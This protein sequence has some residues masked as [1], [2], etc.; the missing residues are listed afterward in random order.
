MSSAIKILMGDSESSPQD[1]QRRRRVEELAQRVSSGIAFNK[2]ASP[3][4]ATQYLGAFVFCVAPPALKSFY[5]AY[6]A[7]T[8]WANFFRASGPVPLSEETP[9][10]LL[11]NLEIAQQLETMGDSESL[12][13]DVQRR[14]RV[15]RLAQRVSAGMAFRKETSPS[16]ATQRPSVLVA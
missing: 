7:L 3:G 13:H 14:R 12:P 10:E 6:P 1:T 5:S 16:G 4:G 2:N 8:C 15:K 11:R 9:S